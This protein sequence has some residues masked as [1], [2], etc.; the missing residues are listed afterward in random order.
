MARW[1]TAAAAILALGYV[2]AEPGIAQETGLEKKQI[3]IAVGGV[4][5]QMPARQ[6][7]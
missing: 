5:A 2:C 6:I 1:K 3:K 7:C 4:A